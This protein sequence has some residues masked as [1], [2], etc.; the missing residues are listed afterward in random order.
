MGREMGKD[1]KGQ[2]YILLFSKFKI[3]ECVNLLNR[4]NFKNNFGIEK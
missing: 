3:L 2:L 4:R 1:G